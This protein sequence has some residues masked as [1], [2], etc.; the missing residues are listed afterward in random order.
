MDDAV[1][2][3]EL[4]LATFRE[5]GDRDGEGSAA[6]GLGN[7]SKQLGELVEAVRWYE[8]SLEL[9]REIG[10]VSTQ[11]VAWV[12]LGYAFLYLG[13]LDRARHALEQSS[14]LAREAGTPFVLSF[15]LDGLGRLAIEEDDS[16]RAV[17]WWEE[18]LALR[19]KIGHGTGIADCLVGLGERWCRAGDTDRARPAL[20]EAATWFREQ[21]VHGRLAVATA[22]LACLPG[23]DP[24]PALAEL[25][26]ADTPDD[27]LRGRWFLFRATGDRPHLDAAKRLLDEALAK[28][29]EEY[30]EGMVARVRLNREILAAWR[31]EFGEDDDSSGG[32]STIESSTRAG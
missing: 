7:V 14:A 9:G 12:N 6:A 13:E 19:R 30:R 25:E 23:G 4:A 27:K 2:Y 28:V 16:T 32:G 11:A 20:E 3:A 17:R 29:P 1:R 18:S 5:I 21:G 31:E 10:S 8:R 22:L 15:A 26:E 24:A